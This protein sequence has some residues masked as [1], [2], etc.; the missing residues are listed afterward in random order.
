MFNVIKVR[1][2]VDGAASVTV[3]ET[4][5]SETNIL[6]ITTSNEFITNKFHNTTPTSYDY[7]HS[8]SQGV[9]IYKAL[10]IQGVTIYC[11]RS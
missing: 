5:S 2:Y 7:P 9:L 10:Y 3:H 4:C 1:H 11:P 6:I 8:H